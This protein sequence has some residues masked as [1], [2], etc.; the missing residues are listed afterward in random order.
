MLFQSRFELLGRHRLAF[1]DYLTVSRYRQNNIIGLH[2]GGCRTCLRELYLNAWI[3]DKSGCDKKE[4]EEN[5]N[6]VYKGC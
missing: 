6:D 3:L 5:K 4:D 2:I 1:V